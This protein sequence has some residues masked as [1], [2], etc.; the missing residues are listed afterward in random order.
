[1]AVMSWFVCAAPWAASLGQ[2]EARP[3]SPEATLR[4]FLQG[5][6]K[7]HGFDDDTTTNY[8][9]AFFDINGDGQKEAI[10]YLMGP[11]VVR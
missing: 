1:M 6:V 7:D 11:L 8:L 3:P 10:V 4:H 2:P 5:Y 9:P